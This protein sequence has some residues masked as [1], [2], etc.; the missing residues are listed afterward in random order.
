MQ[1][2]ETDA[3]KT[4]NDIRATYAFC[5]PSGA[6][7]SLVRGPLINDNSDGFFF[8]VYFIHF[9]CVYFVR[10]AVFCIFGCVLWRSVGRLC[11]SIVTMAAS[12]PGTHRRQ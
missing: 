8:F 5:Q 11:M 4:T 3:R 9:S 1:S 7:C 2:N 6:C 12:V 10:L